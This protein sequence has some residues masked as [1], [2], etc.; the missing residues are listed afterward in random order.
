ELWDQLSQVAGWVDEREAVVGPA[1]PCMA[2][3]VVGE[4]AMVGRELGQ[5]VLPVFQPM[6]LAVDEDKVGTSALHLI[7]EVAAVGVDQRH[8]L[9]AGL[10]ALT[11]ARTTR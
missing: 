3:A 10:E 8:A 2:T 11:V 9:L 4:A 6:D 5:L 7:I 1:G